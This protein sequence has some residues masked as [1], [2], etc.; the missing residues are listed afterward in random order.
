MELEEVRASE[1]P[2]G[3]IATNPVL[4]AEARVVTIEGA[5]PAATGTTFGD[6]LEASL[7]LSL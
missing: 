7:A 3:A 2:F 1:P 5:V 6:L 4:P